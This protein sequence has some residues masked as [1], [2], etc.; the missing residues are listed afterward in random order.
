MPRLPAGGPRLAEII[1]MADDLLGLQADRGAAGEVELQRARHLP[2][3]QQHQDAVRLRETEAPPAHRRDA[4]DA[5]PG[6]AP[7]AVAARR[8]RRP[9][10]AEAVGDH[11]EAP[12]L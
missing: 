3:C 10:P 7:L 12:L 9:L 5:E 1:E 6:E 2:D 11:D 4:A 8:C